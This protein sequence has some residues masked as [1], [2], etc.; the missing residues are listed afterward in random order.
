MEKNLSM[1]SGSAQMIPI[2]FRHATFL[3][4]KIRGL[5]TEKQSNNSFLEDGVFGGDAPPP[6][7]Q[8]RAGYG[9]GRPRAGPGRAG[10][11]ISARKSP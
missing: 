6:R 2:N 9:P 10:L 11:K 1:I 7:L 5:P 8:S 4:L 3:F